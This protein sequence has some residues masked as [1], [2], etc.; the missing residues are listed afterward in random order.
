MWGREKK[1]EAKPRKA[2]RFKKF[3]EEIKHKR[4]LRQQRKYAEERRKEHELELKKKREYAYGRRKGI[5]R[6]EKR[7]QTIKNLKKFIGKVEQKKIEKDKRLIE[8]A[9][10]LVNYIDEAMI[11][12]HP[13]QKH[14]QS[15]LKA[16]WPKKIVN[17]YCDYLWKRYKK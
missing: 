15:L 13:K 11:K 10:E 4:Q 9:E 1:I 8:S 17:Q 5:E 12:G 6:K 14:K 3:I 7:K 16:G 2:H